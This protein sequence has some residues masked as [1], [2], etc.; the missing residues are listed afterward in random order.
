MGLKKDDIE[1]LLVSAIEGGSNYWYRIESEM[2]EDYLKTVFT[3]GLEIS[4]HE[5]E[6][7][8]RKAMLNAETIETGLKVMAEKYTRH[9][10]DALD[11]NADATT[12][13]VFLQ[14]CLFGE[15]IYG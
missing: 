15:V 11:E 10:A 1:S 12:G 13:D 7:V 2:G 5:I 14:C 8:P 4:N 9:Y 6:D 3:T